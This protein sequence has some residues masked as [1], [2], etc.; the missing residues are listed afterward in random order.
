MQGELI[1]SAVGCVPA[2]GHGCRL[3]DG[4]GRPA[5]NPEEVVSLASFH[6]RAK[7]CRCAPSFAGSCITTRS[8][9]I[10]CF[11]AGYSTS[12]R[13]SL[14]ARHFWGSSPTLISGSIS[15]SPT[16]QQRQRMTSSFRWRRP[17]ATEWEVRTVLP[18]AAFDFQQRMA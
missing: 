6:E 15:S 3:P 9:S 8:S 1:D 4:H 13:S 16:L 18:L 10:I 7:G 14:C 17:L 5:L 11:Q 12:R 2:D